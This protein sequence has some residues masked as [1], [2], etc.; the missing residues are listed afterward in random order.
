MSDPT[1]YPG[2]D[3]WDGTDEA[4]EDEPTMGPED[5]CHH[6][7]PFDEDCEDCDNEIAEE[8]LTP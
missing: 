3:P 7:V 4:E 8:E 2:R 6:G 5:Y 1:P